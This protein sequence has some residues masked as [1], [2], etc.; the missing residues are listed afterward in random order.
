MA[1]DPAYL[2][3]RPRHPSRYIQR[4]KQG[5][6]FVQKPG[7]TPGFMIGG[8]PLPVAHR[9][10]Q[11]AP[12]AV[13]LIRHGLGFMPNVTVV[14]SSGT[15]VVGDVQYLSRQEVRLIFSSPFSGEAYLS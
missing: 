8:A 6:V 5:P 1:D 4:P 13:W 7:T 11:S 3:V 10:V 15:H 14:D 9:H 12:E 2:V